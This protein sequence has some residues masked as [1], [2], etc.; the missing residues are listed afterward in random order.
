MG[1]SIKTMNERKREAKVGVLSVPTD[2]ES[3][4]SMTFKVDLKDL[5]SYHLPAQV[6][7]KNTENVFCSFHICLSI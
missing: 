3:V 7:F 4:L 6:I 1:K 5:F 2:G